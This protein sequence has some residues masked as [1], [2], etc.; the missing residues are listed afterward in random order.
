LN[1]WPRWINAI[2]KRTASLSLAQ[3]GAYDRL[4]DHYYAEEQPLPG[5]LDECCRIVGAINKAEREA[6]A[7]VL[8]R[9]FVKTDAGYRNQRAD[10]ELEIGLKKIEAAKSNGKK[11]G[12]PRASIGEEY[13]PIAGVLYAIR[14]DHDR[15]KVG[16]SSNFK[17]RLHQHRRKLGPSIK[18]VH[19]VNVSHMGDAEWDLLSAYDKERDGEIVSLP[20]NRDQD[21]ISEMNRIATRFQIESRSHTQS[22]SQQEP[23]A[24][25]PHPQSTTSDADASGGKPP[26]PASADP[27]PTA[28]DIVFALGVPL[29]TAANVKESNARSFLAMQ[30]KAHGDQRVAEALQRCSVERPIEPVSWLQQQLG[31]IKPGAKAGKHA[32]FDLLDYHDGVTADGHLA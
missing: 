16:V 7:Q 28:K 18:I 31:P 20:C 8:A 22:H 27:P 9:Y 12:R 14:I 19:T 6:V 23:R 21:L 30:A 3:M 25:A 24:K 5:S 11:G 1:Y 2:K 26:P 15:V 10:E 29:L 4:L 13:M 17:S 32:G